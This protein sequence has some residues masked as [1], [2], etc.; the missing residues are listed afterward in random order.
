[1]G[2]KVLAVDDDPDVRAFV[3][4]VL[5]ENGYSPLSAQDGAQG[6]SAIKE[7][8]PDLVILDVLMPK[9]S[10]V[11]LYR[12]LRTDASLKNIPVIVL[13]GIAKKSFLRSQKALTEFKGGEVPEPEAY[14]EK[15]VKAAELAETIKKVVG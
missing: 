12:E 13:S 2:I 10:G 9:G 6:M 15:P 4:T 11:R 7:E 14:L 5:E 1:M 3:A 8:K